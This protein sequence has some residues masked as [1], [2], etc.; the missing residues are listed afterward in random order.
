MS[1]KMEV[2]RDATERQTCY[3]VTKMAWSGLV[4]DACG[5]CDATV[6]SGATQCPTCGCRIANA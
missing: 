4:R 5:N 3:I 6:P 2:K 1:E